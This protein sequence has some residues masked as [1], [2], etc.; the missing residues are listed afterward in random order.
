M[1]T[2]SSRGLR[3]LLGLYVLASMSYFVAGAIAIFQQRFQSY[4]RVEDPFEMDYDTM[5]LTRQREQP[6]SRKATLS[7]G[8]MTGGTA[9][10]RS[11]C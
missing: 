8:C 6:G 10:R 2:G 4:Q 3:F 11:G 9:G 7:S 5:T 1:R